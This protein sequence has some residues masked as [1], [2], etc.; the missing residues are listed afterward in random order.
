MKDQKM[1]CSKYMYGV[2]PAFFISA[3][4][5]AFT[6][7]DVCDGLSRIQQLGFQ[8]YQP[9]VLL[10]E[11]LADWTTGGWKVVHEHGKNLGLVPSQFVAH[12]L[13]YT[14]EQPEQIMSDTG[15]E[16]L[17]RVIEMVKGLGCRTV[18]VPVGRTN[19]SAIRT[20]SEFDQ[21]QR[22]FVNKISRWVA[23]CEKGNLT[24]AFEVVPMSMIGGTE[25]V[26]RM[27]REIGSAGL[28]V[29]YDTGHAWAMNEEVGMIPFQLKGRIFGTHL[30]DNDHHPNLS[31]PVGQGSI[32][33]GIVLR[34]L[35]AS[36]YEGS[37]DLEIHCDEK[38]VDA[39]YKAGLTNLKQYLKS[40][41]ET[42]I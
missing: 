12:F 24:L 8:A 21:L 27:I 13:M 26:I 16:E 5:K 37:L 2:S 29:N 14:F 30:C 17:K 1:S 20:V 15:T 25:G 9:E 31:L 40:I 6:I 3:Y 23:L 7:Q 39:A 4:G 33:W 22:C 11:R 34:N 38:Q 36:G 19:R 10:P 42:K 28:G 41:P 35:L 32:E 18:T